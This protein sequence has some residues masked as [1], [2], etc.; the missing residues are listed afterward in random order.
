MTEYLITENN[1]FIVTSANEN[2]ITEES[3]YL[4]YG[5][6]YRLIFSDVLGN[7]KKVEILKKDYTGD[8]LPMIGGANPVQISWQSTNDYYK[9]IIGSKCTLS[10]LVTDSISYD[11]FYKFDEREYKVVVSYAKSQGEIYLDRVEAD[12]GTVESYECVDNVLNNFETISS[13]YENRVIEDGGT[14]ESISCIS[15]TITD[16]NFYRWGA[17]W[18]GFLVVDRYKEKLSTPPFGIKINAFD[19][20]GTLSNFSAPI[21]YNNNNTPLEL[22]NLTRVKDILL[23]LDLDLDIYIASDIRRNVKGTDFV[24]ETDIKT[25]EVGFEELKGD[26]GLYNAKE[27]LELLL[28]NW[29]LRI[30]Q[31]YN[32]W[33]IVGASNIFDYY[34]KEQIRNEVQSTGVVPS[35]IR[36]RITNQLNSTNKEF[37]NFNRFDKDGVFRKSEISSVLYDNNNELKAIKNNLSREYLQPISQVETEGIYLQTKT[38]FYN[39]GFEYGSFGFVILDN[40]SSDPLAEIATNEISFRGDRSMKL[41]DVAPTTSSPF[42]LCFEYNT[43]LTDIDVNEISFENIS[44]SLKYYIKCLTSSGDAVNST[45]RYAITLVDSDGTKEWIR[46]TKSWSL[47]TTIIQRQEIENSEANVFLKFNEDFTDTGLVFNVGFQFVSIKVTIY[48]TVCSNSDYQTTYFDNLE[49]IKKE[50][51]TKTENQ[52][53][54]SSL[55]NAG[56]K[57]TTKK[58]KL[59]ADLQPEFYRTRDNYGTF[60]STN[61]WK[62]RI[63]LINQNIANDYREYVSEYNGMFRNLKV[64]PLSMHNKIWFYWPGFETDEQSTVIDGLTYDI[65]SAEFKLKSHLP[66]DD[67]DVDVEFIVN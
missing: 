33:Y 25:L 35:G 6:K 22:T 41:T 66:N 59:L 52:K 16:D 29:N 26:F 38:S 31:S 27:M 55:T 24:F 14:V 62:G 23:N 18:S 17:Y 47:V 37:I 39:S 4:S 43:P 34:I 36:S 2:L 21:G 15:E 10:L 50:E 63:N 13:N 49:V 28:R 60:N 9:P 42:A 8:V 61:I 7:G 20:L 45:V 65:K 12:G 53:F 3:Q 19:G 54:V 46:E 58:L 56:I 64:Q 11:D 1:D 67:D 44:W 32:R 40:A 57:T 48:N 5:V 51:N 30:Y